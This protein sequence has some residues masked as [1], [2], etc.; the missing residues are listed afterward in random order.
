M[1][2]KNSIIGVL[3]GFGVLAM[4]LPA[5]AHHSIALQFDMT[6]TI[7]VEGVI[8]G[9]EWR[10]PHAWLNIEVEN[11]AGE[12]EL[13]K[14]EFSSANSLIRRGWR[15]NDLPIGTVVEVHGLPSRDGSRVVDGEEIILADGR[16]LLEGARPG[17]Q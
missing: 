2:S 7:S 11:D 17:E 6:K 15:P 4:T 14:V 12:P 13:W 1:K 5:I 9:L 10:N 16:E 3:A 8:V